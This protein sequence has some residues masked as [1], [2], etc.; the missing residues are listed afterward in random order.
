MLTIIGFI[1]I[2][3]ALKPLLKNN[4]KQYKMHQHITKEQS[5]FI[6]NG[7]RMMK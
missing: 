4:H 7:G 5:D 1:I 6:A 3:L 2:S